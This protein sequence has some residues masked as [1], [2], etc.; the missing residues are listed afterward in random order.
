MQAAV[1]EY[2]QLV[3]EITCRNI[4]RSTAF[5]RTLGFELVRAEE[6]FAELSWGGR[7]LF[8]DEKPSYVPPQI[9][10]GNL[11]VMVP[12]V[13]AIWER[14]LQLELPV[15]SAIENRYYGLRDFTVMDPDGF[16]VR[17]A[18]EIPALTK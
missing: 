3:L 18:T 8:L 16:G 6:H 5:Y 10:A 11:R 13:D 1:S 15:Y 14:C 12:D 2:Q 9:P 4:L 7:L 17:F